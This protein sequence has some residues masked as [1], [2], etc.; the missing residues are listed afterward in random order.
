[1]S[2]SKWLV[3]LAVATA[4]GHCSAQGSEMSLLDLAKA[5]IGFEGQYDMSSCGFDGGFYAELDSAAM[6]NL[7][8]DIS[9]YLGPGVLLRLNVRDSEADLPHAVL[10]ALKDKCDLQGKINADEIAKILGQFSFSKARQ[11]VEFPSWT[12]GKHQIVTWAVSSPVSGPVKCGEGTSSPDMYVGRV[13][14]QMNEKV[15]DIQG[16]WMEGCRQCGQYLEHYK[17]NGFCYGWTCEKSMFGVNLKRDGSAC[18]GLAASSPLSSMS[19]SN[20]STV[21][22]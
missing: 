11:T 22:V 10:D 2:F 16:D 3:V 21:V 13:G 7:G 8:R 14:L 9:K 18:P 19:A 15:Q 17:I 1:M 12:L 5:L 20:R 4:V 6:A